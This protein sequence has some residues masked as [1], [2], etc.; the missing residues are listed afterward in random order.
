MYVM[1]KV[2]AEKFED[3]NGDPINPAGTV[4]TFAG[5]TAPG[6]F[7]ECD[8]RIVSAIAYPDLFAA[9]GYLYGGSGD[10]FNLPDLNNQY[11]RGTSSGGDVGDNLDATYLRTAMNDWSDTDASS[12]QNN[13]FVGQAYANPDDSKTPQTVP[14][15]MYNGNGSQFGGILYDNINMTAQN[16]STGIQPQFISM[17]PKSVKLLMCIKT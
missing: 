4:I 5:A 12:T 2:R 10:D 17:R 9:I 14:G 8:G 11:V 3:I 15:T 7:L 16:N 1:S 13:L 6:G